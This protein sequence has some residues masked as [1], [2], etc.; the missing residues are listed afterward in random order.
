LT[1][2]IIAIVGAS[3]SGKTLFAQ[4]I[5]RELSQE[6]SKQHDL[7]IIEEDAYYHDQSHLPVKHRANTNYDHPDSLDHDLLLQHLTQLRNG[8]TVD[9][10]VY[11][12]GEHTRANHTRRVKPS[13]V[14]IIEGILLL[15]NERLREQFDIKLFIDTP[16]DVCLLRRIA[17]DMEERN[18]SL[19]SISEQ[20]EATVRPMFYQF[21]EP[22][23]KFADIV[24]TRGGKNR[25]AIDMLKHRIQSILS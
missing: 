2:S 11:D 12:Y 15:T 3:A 4:T 8:E 9:V 20:Y 19:K 17:R 5:Y 16:L 14:I 1:L 25:I 22:C 18:R 21:I 24:V 10:P 23:K 6:I 13:K 7:A